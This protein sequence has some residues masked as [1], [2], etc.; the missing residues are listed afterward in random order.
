MFETKDGW[1]RKIENHDE[2]TKQNYE[3]K[4]ELGKD[5]KKYNSQ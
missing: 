3:K 4:E 1:K 5:G 2:E